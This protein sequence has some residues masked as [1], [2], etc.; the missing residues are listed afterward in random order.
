MGLVILGPVLSAHAAPGVDM[1]QI[2][3]LAALDTACAMYSLKFVCS[4][5]MFASLFNFFCILLLSLPL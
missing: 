1:I 5:A 2:A 3:T 4:F